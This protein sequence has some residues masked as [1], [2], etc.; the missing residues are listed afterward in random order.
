MAH[1][2]GVVLPAPRRCPRAARRRAGGDS[3][4]A[5][6]RGAAHAPF[7][8][9]GRT[10]PAVAGRHRPSGARGA[11]AAPGRRPAGRERAPVPAAHTGGDGHRVHARW[12]EAP[13]HDSSHRLAAS[14]RQPLGR[15]RIARAAVDPGHAPAPAR[16]AG[17][18]EWPASGGHRSAA[19]RRFHRRAHGGRGHPSASA[20]SAAR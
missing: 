5:P 3:Q 14:R 18:R 7:R 15:R 8:L 6:D 16:C 11:V 9:Q 2:T 13:A 17:V 4:T 10:P 19:S 12:Q 1:R 20:P